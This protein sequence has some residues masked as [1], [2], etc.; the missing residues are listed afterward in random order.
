MHKGSSNTLRLSV[1][2]N[3]LIMHKGSSNTLWLLV[4]QNHLIMHKGS[5]NTLRL[6][7]PQNHLVHK[8]PPIHYGYGVPKITL[9]IWLLKHLTAIGSPKSP[10]AYGSS[11]TL[12][13]LVPQNHLMHMAPQTP[14]GYWFLQN[15]LMHKASKRPL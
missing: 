15:H 2:Q 1:A 6:L 9:C 4:P 3:H 12:Q 13:L 11:N 5:S 10:Y 7:V 14:Y 8:A